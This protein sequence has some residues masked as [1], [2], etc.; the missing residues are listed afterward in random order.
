MFR[1]INCRTVQLIDI[2]TQTKSKLK[3]DQKWPISKHFS[4]SH[5]LS[6]KH[7]LN[8]SSIR[9]IKVCVDSAKL[10]FE[11]V[12]LFIFDCCKQ[13]FTRLYHP[14]IHQPTQCPS[15]CYTLETSA[16]V[17]KSWLQFLL[18]LR[19]WNFKFYNLFM[20]LFPLFVIT[21]I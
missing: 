3:Q 2:I 13:S 14:S 20:I 4:A 6:N 17:S 7:K 15:F 5:C 18:A 10:E 19:I 11:I 16:L 21:K 8:L 9:L 1:N 12:Y